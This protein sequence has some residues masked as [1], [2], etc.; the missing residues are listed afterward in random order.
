MAKTKKQYKEDFFFGP[1]L[2]PDSFKE[3]DAFDG[4]GQPLYRADAL[5]YPNLFIG[6]AHYVH[7]L[8]HH[9]KIPYITVYEGEAYTPSCNVHTYREGVLQISALILAI[10]PKVCNP[11]PEGH[12]VYEERHL[13]TNKQLAA[14][15]GRVSR[16]KLA[17]L[18]AAFCLGATPN[19]LAARL[20]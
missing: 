10:N 16:E 19:D 6:H 9:Y 20:R 5:F 13:S 11:P 7:K 8:M 4:D 1:F 14:I 3:P 12:N 15:L 18:V 2:T 17:E